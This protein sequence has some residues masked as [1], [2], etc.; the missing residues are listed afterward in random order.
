MVLADDGVVA[1]PPSFEQDILPLLAKK[2]HA[3]HGADDQQ[4]QLDLRSLSE[5]MRGGESGPAGEFGR[6]PITDGEDGRDHNRHA[7]STLMAGGGFKATN[8]AT[9]RSKTASASAICMPQS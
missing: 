9:N 1:Q 2:C 5:I 6:V 8:S 7:F 4:A 3:S